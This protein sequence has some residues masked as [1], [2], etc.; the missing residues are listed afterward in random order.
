MHHRLDLACKESIAAFAAW[1]KHALAAKLGHEACIDVL[2]NNAAILGSDSLKLI[3]SGI[4]ETLY[5]NHFGH[6]YLTHLLL[7]LFHQSH[8][9]MIINVSSDMSYKMKKQRGD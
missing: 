4:E 2:I 6:F 5:V 8:N 9:P 1:V 3:G 7:P